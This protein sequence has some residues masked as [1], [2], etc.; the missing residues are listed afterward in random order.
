MKLALLLKELHASEDKVK[1]LEDKRLEA[2]CQII[3]ARKLK[4]DAQ[5]ELDI[6]TN[7]HER[8]VKTFQLLDTILAEF[9]FETKQ[10]LASEQRAKARSKQRAAKT[11]EQQ[12]EDV[13]ACLKSLPS[14][15]RESILKTLTKGAN[16]DNIET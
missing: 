2:R 10:R 9:K 4:A 1:R 12:M 11:M 13:L 16:N 15:Q 7:N 8:K 3:D 14:D 6:A 5:A